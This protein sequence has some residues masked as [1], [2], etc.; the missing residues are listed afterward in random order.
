MSEQRRQGF[1]TR[2]VHAGE[3]PPRPDFVPTTTPIYPSRRFIYEKV[4][5]L[6]AVFGGEAPGYIYSPLRQP[7]R[8]GAGDGGRGAG[9]RP[10]RPSPSAAAWRRCT[11]RCWRAVS[12]AATEIVAAR[13]LY[14]AT[15]TLLNA[16][17][18]PLGVKTVFV[19]MHRPGARRGGAGRARS[20]GRS[21][22]E[23]DLQPA[24]ARGRSA[25]AGAAGAGGRGAD[26]DN[27]FASPLPAAPG[28]TA[29]TSSSTARRS[30]SAATAT[31]RAARSAGD[32]T[33]GG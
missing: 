14:G 29:P 25:G 7:D 22:V 12:A 26:V 8:P 20:R 18:S 2:A 11:R 6:D 19:D 21:S 30:T 5:E 17:L 24:G 15:Y 9:G 3:R 27:T 1:G 31:S 28:R 10:R 23:S 33:A 32:G 13:D 16:I 4:D